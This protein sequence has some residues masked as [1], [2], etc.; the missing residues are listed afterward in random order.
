MNPIPTV[1]TLDVSGTPRVTFGRLVRVEL[2]KMADTRAGRWLMISVAV[3]TALIL[4]IQM[5]VV[6]AQSVDVSFADFLLGMN[7][8]MGILLPVLGILSITSEWSQRTAMVTFTL[9]PSRLRVMAAKLAGILVL[10]VAAVV[11]GLLLAVLANALYGILSGHDPVWDSPGTLALDYLVSWVL[12]M[13]QGFAYGAV[14][15][16]SAAAI[17]VFFVYSFVLPIPFA[18][19]AQL[20]DWFDGLRPWIDFNSAQSPLLDGSMAGRQWAHLAVSGLIWIVV[21]LV[22]GT[23]RIQRAEVK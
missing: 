3:L 19:A 15:L 22:L 23:W 5:W 11:V 1:A 9:E 21:P 13:V 7:T 4:V 14:F 17:V 10:S 18:I 16:N 6:V 2:R 20:M 12:G 8:A